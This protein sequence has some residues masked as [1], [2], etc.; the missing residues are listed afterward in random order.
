MPS[1]YQ[2][3]R[4]FSN[5][6]SG[7]KT[8]VHFTSPSVVTART[9]DSKKAAA[10]EAPAPT[11]V[12]DPAPIE[13]T[14]LSKRFKP[15][16]D[17][18]HDFQKAILFDLSVAN[19]SA[20]AVRAFDGVITFTDLLDNRI[21]SLKL[22]INQSIGAGASMKWSGSIDFNQFMD[23]HRRLRDEDQ[24]NLKTK[25]TLRKVLYADGTNKEYQ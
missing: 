11:K 22:A 21:L 4:P 20:K 14:L 25:F 8:G 13:I 2:T 16:N 9:E 15:P 10:A 18:A 12:D 24:S 3:E 17:N 19:R 6:A 1:V 5:L 23:D 7:P